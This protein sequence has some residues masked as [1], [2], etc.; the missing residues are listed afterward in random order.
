MLRVEDIMTRDPVTVS[1]DTPLGEVVELM[2]A[3]SCRQLPVMY[4]D[5]LVGIVTDRDIRLVMN[6]PLTLHERADDLALLNHV[7]VEACMT[8]NPMTVEASSSA[9]LA[10]DLMRTYKFG[11]LPVVHEGRLVG[12]LTV[13]DILKSYI[14]LLSAQE[15]TG[16]PPG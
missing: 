13:S 6:S 16:K 11:G 14:D 9:A 15:E 10:A 1:P 2:K 5:R 4:G 7:P 8:L 12:I 3:H